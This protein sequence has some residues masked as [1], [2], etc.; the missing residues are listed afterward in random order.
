MV[1]VKV[2]RL[3]LDTSQAKKGAQEGKKAVDEYTTSTT[4]AARQT[5]HLDARFKKIA[6]SGGQLRGIFGTIFGVS[7]ALSVRNAAQQIASFDEQIATLGGVSRATASEMEQLEK[8]ARELGATTKFS[9]SEAAEAQINLARAGF[10]VNEVMQVTPAVLNTAA[11]ALLS[12]GETA[13]VATTLTAQFGLTA[14]EVPGALNDLLVVANRTKSTVDSLALSMKDAGTIGGL[15]AEDTAEVAAALG[16]IQDRGVAAASAGIGYRQAVLQLLAPTAAAKRQI[17]AL[18]LE[19][20]DIDP[21][22]NKVVDVFQKFGEKGLTAGQAARIFGDRTAQVALILSQSTDKLREL[23]QAARDNGDES[24]RLA[25]IQQ[26]SLA[27]AFKTLSSTLQEAVLW[28]GDKG[29]KPALQDAS[30]LLTDTIRLLIGTNT[31]VSKFGETTEILAGVIVGSLVLA[32]VKA[33]AAVTGLVVAMAT[34]PFGLAAVALV[35]LVAGLYKFRNEVVTIEGRT[36]RLKDL[37]VNSLDTMAA[38][39]DVFK[40]SLELAWLSLEAAGVTAFLKIRDTALGAFDAII[41]QGYEVKRRLPEAFGGLT[42]NDAARAIAIENER[43]IRP[44]RTKKTLEGYDT[45]LQDKANELVKALEDPALTKLLDNAAGAYEENMVQAAKAAEV[46]IEVAKVAFMNFGFIG[47]KTNTE[48]EGSTKKS[49][50]ALDEYVASF[51]ELDREQQKATETIEAMFATLQV[52]RDSIG[53]TN[54]ARQREIDLIRLRSE[55]IKAGIEDTGDLEKRYTDLSK[56]IERLNKSQALGD[57]FGRA[58]G[59]MAREVI[60]GAESMGDAFKNLGRRLADAALEALFIQP[61]IEALSGSAGQGTGFAGLFAGFLKNAN[62]NVFSNGNVVPMANGAVVNSPTFFPM[63]GG[64]M[65]LMGEAGAEAVM[66]L[67]R[68]S[69]G[70]LGVRAQ[71]QTSRPISVTM[72]VNG[73]SDSDSFRRSERQVLSRLQKA[74]K[75]AN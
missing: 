29:L 1:D 28:L 48:M 51:Q 13:E 57:D 16:I 67:S 25:E 8:M 15:L 12:L 23:T 37:F 45:K 62:G 53:L 72:N 31:E 66:P 58:F 59:D 30:Q 21:T 38:A 63:S 54:E 3:L 24:K 61:L 47:V 39:G 32:L 60:T 14:S 22:V 2:L 19:F 52:E 40:V 26:R 56:E 42:V 70:K 7:L 9:A 6:I 11:A 18:G 5:D 43:D 10:E 27:G 36:L 20:S 35:G 73:V 65:G 75:Q 44:Q 68:G 64:K 33:T 74:L 46:A 34:N 55:A 49:K 71:G 69:D 50:V 41:L 17:A 4:R